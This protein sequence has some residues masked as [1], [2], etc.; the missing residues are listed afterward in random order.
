MPLG[1]LRFTGEGS[2]PPSDQ[3]NAE[4]ASQGLPDATM[5]KPHGAYGIARQL[6]GL[7]L[8]ADPMGWGHVVYVIGITTTGYWDDLV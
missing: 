4:V 2:T 1:W 6:V 8:V 7:S 5:R 3:R